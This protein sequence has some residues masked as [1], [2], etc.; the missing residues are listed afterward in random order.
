MATRSAHPGDILGR[1]LS[2]IVLKTAQACSVDRTPEGFRCR[3]LSIC[4]SLRGNLRFDHG[5]LSI[6]DILG[7]FACASVRR[8]SVLFVLYSFSLDA[9]RWKRLLC[10][11][12]GGEEREMQT[13]FHHHEA[14]DSS[15]AETVN[16]VAVGSEMKE[17]HRLNGAS[18]NTCCPTNPLSHPISQPFI[19]SSRQNPKPPNPSST[20]V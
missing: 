10:V 12:W 6:P 4:P 18:G 17:G 2:N 13:P 16:V 8:R 9:K 15:R 1:S 20:A 5:W 3:S 14:C 7:H 11:R 19:L